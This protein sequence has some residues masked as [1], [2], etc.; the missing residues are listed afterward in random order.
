MSSIHDRQ[1]IE[2]HPELIAE[3]LD[4]NN[5]DRYQIVIDSIKYICAYSGYNPDECIVADEI[6]K[7][8]LPKNGIIENNYIYGIYETSTNE[9]VAWIQYY[10]EFDNKPIVFLCV[11][12]IRKEYQSKGYGK[13]ILEHFMDIWKENRMEKAILNVDLK[14]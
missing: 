5:V 14:N 4:I 2:N 10:L 1:F 11:L 8:S 9:A 13:A 3:K 6:T 12:Y 7:P